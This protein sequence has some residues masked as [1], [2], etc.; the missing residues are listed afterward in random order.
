MTTEEHDTGNRL[1]NEEL[2]AKKKLAYI[3]VAMHYKKYYVRLPWMNKM[4][5]QK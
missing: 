4:I 2:K 5:I 1:D 3:E